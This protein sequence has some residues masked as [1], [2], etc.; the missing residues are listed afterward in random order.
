[1]L[2]NVIFY[3]T[4]HAME[5]LF[6]EKKDPNLKIPS[7]CPEFGRYSYLQKQELEPKFHLPVQHRIDLLT[8]LLQSLDEF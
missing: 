4:Y 7:H 5:N 1:M 2:K 3:R 6:A 8:E